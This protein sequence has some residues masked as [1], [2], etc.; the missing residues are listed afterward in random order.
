MHSQKRKG[1][2]MK[3]CF[4]KC[5][6]DKTEGSG[7]GGVYTQMTPPEEREF[8]KSRGRLICMVP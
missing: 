1:L 6:F 2:G 5:I 3:Y 7:G 4:V 8:K